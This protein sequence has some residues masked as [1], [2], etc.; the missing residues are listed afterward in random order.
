M[1]L[2]PR[3]P[4][5]RRWLA[6]DVDQVVQRNAALAGESRDPQRLRRYL[7]ALA[8]N[9]AGVVE[10][11]KATAAPTAEMARH[12]IWLRD[13]LG[14]DLVTGGSCTPAHG[15]SGSTTGSTLFRSV[16]SGAKDDQI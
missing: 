13:E 4:L 10:H 9:S 11:I 12:L 16:L 5:R 6:S 15:R 2:Q 14:D 3:E 1:A 7:R 8:A